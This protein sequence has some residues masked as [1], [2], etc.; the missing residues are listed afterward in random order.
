V[1]AGQILVNHLVCGSLTPHFAGPG[2][3]EHSR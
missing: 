3:S 1:V 2:T